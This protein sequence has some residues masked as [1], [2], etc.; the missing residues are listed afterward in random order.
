MLRKKTFTE[1]MADELREAEEVMDVL[2]QHAIANGPNLARA[3]YRMYQ[4][5]Q[6]L[7]EQE[8]EEWNSD[9]SCGPQ[10]TRRMLYRCQAAAGPY[11]RPE[12]GPCEIYTPNKQ[13]GVSIC[14]VC[15]GR[16]VA[17]IRQTVRKGA[18]VAREVA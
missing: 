6:K 14:D 9:A 11:H 10:D 1:M 18:T 17:T 4:E 3:Y 12:D 7:A 13:A 5:I 15:K 16:L 8:L 2:D